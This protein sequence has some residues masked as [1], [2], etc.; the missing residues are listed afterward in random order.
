MKIKR[1]QIGCLVLSPV[2]SLELKHLQF[3]LKLDVFCLRL[4]SLL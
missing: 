1:S 2:N 4:L 3:P